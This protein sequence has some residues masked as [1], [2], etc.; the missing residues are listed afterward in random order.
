MPW[1]TGG[2]YGGWGGHEYHG[3]DSGQ[4]FNPVVFVHG[5]GRDACDWNGHAE[6]MLDRGYWGDELWATTFVGTTGDDDTPTH[7][8]MADQLDEFVREVRNYTG[9]SQV[10]IVGHSLGVTGS[11]WWIDSYDRY[12]WVNTFV[13][14]A[15]AFSGNCWCSCCC[16]QGGAGEPCQFIAAQCNYSGHPLREM[17]APD[18]TPAGTNWYTIRGFYDEVFAPCGLD[19][20]P[21][22]DGANNNV[23]YTDHDGVRIYSKSDVFEWTYYNN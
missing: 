8:D 18:P 16:D 15:G 9:A 22:L 11:Y 14:I 12:D 19:F 7:E 2:A 4:L 5:N 21:Y 3:T 17:Q 6:Y 10:D 23:Y 13:G 1:N 20:S